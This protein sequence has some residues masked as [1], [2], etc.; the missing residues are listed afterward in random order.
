MNEARKIVRVGDYLPS[1]ANYV[2]SENGRE[3][4]K[5]RNRHIFV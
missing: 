4:V 3:N 5:K 1:R 2:A